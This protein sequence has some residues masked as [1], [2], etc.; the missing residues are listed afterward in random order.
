MKGWHDRTT[1]KF[2]RV[3]QILLAFLLTS[4]KTYRFSQVGT[5]PAIKFNFVSVMRR[6]WITLAFIFGEKKINIGCTFQNLLS[7]LGQILHRD[8]DLQTNQLTLFFV[9][10]LL[11]V[12][13][14]FLSSEFPF[15]LESYFIILMKLPQSQRNLCCVTNS[16]HASILHCHVAVD[17]SAEAYDKRRSKEQCN[18]RCQ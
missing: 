5:S 4:D 18:Q 16:K 11:P 15:L 9:I 6:K 3:I 12:G 14:I 17:L 7:Q 8:E 13:M 10:C 1:Q 2:S